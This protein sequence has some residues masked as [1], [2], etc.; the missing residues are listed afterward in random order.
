MIK[1]IEIGEN[2]GCLLIIV[3]ICTMVVLVNIF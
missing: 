3:V 2:L 1:R